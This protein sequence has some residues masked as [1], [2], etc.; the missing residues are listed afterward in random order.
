MKKR[1][2]VFTIIF[3]VLLL[4]CSSPVAPILPTEPFIPQP[5]QITPPAQSEPA[6]DTA[7]I[8]EP[9]SK[10]IAFAR[11][12]GL[13]YSWEICTMSPDG[14]QIQNITNSY[15]ADL[16]PSW[17]PDGSKIV[18]E[19]SREGHIFKSIYITDISENTTTCITSEIKTP[20]RFPAWSPD[21]KKIAYSYMKDSVGY[22]KYPFAFPNY[23]LQDLYD[24]SQFV[25][26]DIFIMNPDGSDKQYVTKG[27]GASWFPDSQQIAFTRYSPGV[28][29][30]CRINIDGKGKKNYASIP[31]YNKGKRLP[32]C[33]YP[34][35]SVS[36]DGK[37]IAYEQFDNAQIKQDVYVISLDS[38]KATNITS[39]YVG[40]CYCP[41]WSPDS[42]KIVFTQLDNSRFAI[43]TVDTSGNNM[44]EIIKNGYWPAWQQ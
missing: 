21:G 35:I 16:H 34:T 42:T 29:D 10:R 44:V 37:W 31:Q 18:F 1:T 41:S 14:S 17:S 4:G 32:D 39:K 22:P 25:V 24:N 15:S 5:T 28:W 26:D 33:P 27:W 43:C 13:P 7:K 2:L 9:P 12:L 8:A 6:I 38:G 3:S 40:D 23:A 30:I 20:C 36:P 19:S 11:Y